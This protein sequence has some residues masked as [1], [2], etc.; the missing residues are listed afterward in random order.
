M[1]KLF[2]R[3]RRHDGQGAG[4]PR[5]AVVAVQGT[6]LKVYAP[7]L[8]KVELETLAASIQAEIVYLPRGE[9]SANDELEGGEAGAGRGRRGRG[10]GKAG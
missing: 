1:S 6:D 10:W 5:F 7:H 2:V 8:R 4:R 3:Q 9:K